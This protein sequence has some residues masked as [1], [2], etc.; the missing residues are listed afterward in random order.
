MLVGCKKAVHLTPRAAGWTDGWTGSSADIILAA[1]GTFM[2]QAGRLSEKPTAMIYGTSDVHES[3]SVPLT[4]PDKNICN[5]SKS[6]AGGIKYPCGV[7]GGVETPPAEPFS[8]C[9]AKQ[10]RFGLPKR[11]RPLS[12]GLAPALPL[13]NSPGFAGK[14]RDS[15][16]N[17]ARVKPTRRLS[18]RSQLGMPRP[19]ALFP[20]IFPLA[21]PWRAGVC[22]ALGIHRCKQTMSRTS[23]GSPPTHVSTAPR[24]PRQ[25]ARVAAALQ[26]C[27]SAVGR[28]AG[29]PDGDSEERRR[30]ARSSLLPPSSGS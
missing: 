2:A 15:R 22:I 17:K 6:E 1:Y 28:D 4:S 25:T 7:G 27:S 10:E 26:M 16:G 29:P 3:V 18:H 5:M 23:L 19:P 9:L 21:W 20:G 8:G 11:S 24:L 13:C 30:M 12:P 14:R